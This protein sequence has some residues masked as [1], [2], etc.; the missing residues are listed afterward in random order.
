M[1]LH[2]DEYRSE[3]VTDWIFAICNNDDSGTVGR[4]ATLFW[5]I[6]HNRN[7]HVWNNNKCTPIQVGRTTFVMW[8][9]WFSV[10][11]LQQPIADL[12][13]TSIVSQ[14]TKPDVGWIK[15]N[16]DACFVVDTGVT[17]SACCFC[18][19]DGQFVAA[20]TTWQK[21]LLSQVEGEVVALFCAMEET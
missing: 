21:T 11:T 2:N 19:H 15:C 18:N 12:R 1:V 6:W 10:N 17:T 5:C 20:V 13:A 9:E 3:S 8:N 4:V 14:W 7:E 16:I